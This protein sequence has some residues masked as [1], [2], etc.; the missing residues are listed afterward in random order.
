MTYLVS[1][2]QS[3]IASLNVTLLLGLA[4]W[5]YGQRS[6]SLVALALPRQ[7]ADYQI[8][9]ANPN[10]GCLAAGI[11]GDFVFVLRMELRVPTRPCNFLIRM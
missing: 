8:D 7:P 2:Q 6:A 1:L 5:T 9:S 4:G 3:S 10:K 11:R